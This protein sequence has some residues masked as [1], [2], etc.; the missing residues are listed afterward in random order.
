MSEVI[1]VFGHIGS[2]KSHFSKLISE[3]YL[4]EYL[5]CDKIFK[6]QIIPNELFRMSATKLFKQINVD[7]YVNDK[8]N[9]NELKQVLFINEEI[10]EEFNQIVRTFLNPILQE[11]IRNNDRVLIEMA[12]LTMNPI[13]YICDKL[14]CVCYEI[15]D[16]KTILDTV[17][18]R[19]PELKEG[20]IIRVLNYQN[21]IYTSNTKDK[22]DVIYSRD[23]WGWTPD[24]L[25]LEQFRASF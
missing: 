21:R 3:H 20:I 17:Q 1:G 10:T 7:A 24:K 6:E 8:W 12:T 16:V 23:Y 2:G 11:H 15:Y 25:L 14:F 22:F 13:K 18:K 4:Y 19:N 5:D 9:V